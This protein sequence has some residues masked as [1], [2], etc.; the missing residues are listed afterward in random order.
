[1][2]LIISSGIFAQ[3]SKDAIK[4]EEFIIEQEYQKAIDYKSKKFKKLDGESIYLKGIALYLNSED[5]EAIRYFDKAIEKDFKEV[6]VYFYKAWAQFEIH[7]YYEAILSFE[8]ALKID[9][10]NPE[11]YSG[12][13][14]MYYYLDIP[15]DAAEAFKRSLLLDDSDP[16]IYQYLGQANMDIGNYEECIENY[17]NA[18]EGFGIDSKE[19]Q[20]CHYNMALSQQLA[21]VYSDAKLSFTK[22]LK[23]YPDD[24][25]A[26]TKL[27]QTCYALENFDEAIELEAQL[28]QAYKDKKLP[29]HLN[30]MY[31]FDQFNWN[32]QNVMAFKAYEKYEGEPVIWKHRFYLLDDDEEII[33]KIETQLDSLDS[34]TTPE[35]RYYLSMLENDTIYIYT[36]YNYTSD[37]SYLSLK[38]AVLQILNEE[39]PAKTKMGN[40]SAWL[41]QQ[42]EILLDGAGTSYKKAIKVSSIAEEYEWLAKN[43]PGYKFIQQ[44]LIFEDGTPYDVL[45]FEL[46]KGERKKIYFDISSFFGEGF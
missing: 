5:R 45:E 19:Y 21:G 3:R 16:T 36:H 18:C 1:M 41:S 11:L 7:E 38:N 42:N 43:Y 14:I 24:Y 17:R 25:Q 6:G 9:P 29:Q 28:I 10:A 44:S 15:Q 2:L 39:V 33:K 12:K 26:L 40:Y 13:G 37:S 8:E 30:E 27:I 31:C 32:G 46:K 22:H 23:L 35:D 20:S 4:I 34:T